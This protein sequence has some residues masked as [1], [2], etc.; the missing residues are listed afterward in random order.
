MTSQSGSGW[1]EI[2]AKRIRGLEEASASLCSQDI[3]GAGLIRVANLCWTLTVLRRAFSLRI[4]ARYGQAYHRQVWLR[5]HR[6]GPR[7]QS[8]RHEAE[9]GHLDNVRRREYEGATSLFV[10]IRW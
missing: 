10:T 8:G 6:A 5:F 7:L 9:A 2:L 1:T 3:G 4:S